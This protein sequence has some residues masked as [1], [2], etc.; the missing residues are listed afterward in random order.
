MNAEAVVR[1]IQDALTAAEPRMSQKEMS[2]T[3]VELKRKVVTDTRNRQKEQAEKMRLARLAFLEQNKQ[4]EGVK[5]TASGLQYKV[6][7][8]GSGKSPEPKDTVTVNYRGTL[9]SGRPLTQVPSP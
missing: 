4:K 1:G 7:Q 2:A 9:I 5:T 6:I 3:L 8:A